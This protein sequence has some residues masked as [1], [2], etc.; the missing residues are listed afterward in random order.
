MKV[1]TI[2]G[3]MKFAKE[4]QRIAGVLAID[5][6]WCILQCVYDL[7]FANLTS[8][9]LN[10]LK[11]EHLKRIEL[12]DA[13]Y[14]VNIDGYIGNST[15]LEIEYATKLGKEVIY[16]DLTLLCEKKI[17]LHK[18]TVDELWFRSDCMEDAKTMSYNAGYNVEYKGYHK[19]TGCIDFPKSEWANWAEEK[20]NNPN[21]FYAYILDVE[22]RKFVGY[23]NFNKNQET[24]KAT[25]GI[26][27]R[28][29]YRGNG[30]M[31][32]SMEKLI[33]KAKELGVKNLTDTVPKNRQNAL[34]VF[35]AFG[36]EKVGEFV[37][38]KFDKDEVVYNIELKL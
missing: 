16:H 12:S 11:N 26:V 7:D 35:Y 27:I 8:E 29:E 2:C 31:R 15:R 13:I 30:Y 28:D 22:T 25:M 38:K 18:P 17:E 23:V 9:D 34:K 6:G 4:M 5:K 1:V 37:T 20:L 19:D 32:R 10:L 3:S 21:F 24:K 14:V 33:E 36:F